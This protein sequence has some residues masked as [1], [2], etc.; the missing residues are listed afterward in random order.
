R[1]TAPESLRAVVPPAIRDVTIAESPAEALELAGRAATTPIICVAGSLFLV[2]DV[3]R[4]L[5][6][7]D[8]PCSLDR[9]AARRS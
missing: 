1:A 3:L 9:G 7:R 6:G 5:A 4:H 2:G 8:E